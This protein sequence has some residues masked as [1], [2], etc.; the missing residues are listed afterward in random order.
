MFEY[1]GGDVATV[2]SALVRAFGEGSELVRERRL[3]DKASAQSR[4]T[5]EYG[6]GRIPNGNSPASFSS[7]MVGM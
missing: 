7:G 5:Q 4:I 1:R 2:I 6:I 3:S